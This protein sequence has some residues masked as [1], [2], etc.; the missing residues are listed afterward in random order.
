MVAQFRQPKLDR[1]IHFDQRSRSF[2]VAPFVASTR[3]K[4]TL[5]ELPKTLPLDQGQ[6]GA[7][8][9]FGWSTELAVGPVIERVSN[10]TAETYYRGA[11]GED[12][13][14]GNDFGGDGASV[15][16]GA[17][18]GKRTGLVTS[19]KWAFGVDQVVAA[20]CAIGPVILGINWYD[21]MY[22]TDEKGRVLVN[23]SLAG[24]HCICTTGYIPAADAEKMGLGKFDVIQWVN[25][26]GKAYGLGG[27]GYIRRVDLDTLLKQDGEAV[28]A[29]DA[30]REQNRKQ[31]V[32]GIH[33]HLDSDLIRRVTSP[34]RTD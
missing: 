16:A 2:S 3:L 26:W 4:K 11:V 7:C 27:V 6:E 30:M 32:S 13:R 28:I 5:W 9:G 18:F 24:G 21:S 20:L 25:T 1:K 10:S 34:F 15:L 33:R 31:L 22:E 19:Y 29:Q 8:V 14:M 17:K 12:H 23:G